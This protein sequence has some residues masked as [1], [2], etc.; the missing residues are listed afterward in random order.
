MTFAQFVMLT[1]FPG[2]ST[3][4]RGKRSL[5]AEPPRDRRRPG[6]A[7]LAD[8]AGTAAE[9]LHAASG[10]ERPRRSAAGRRASGT[11]STACRSIWER[12]RGRS[13]RSRRGLAFVLISKLYRQMYANTGIATDS[14][15]SQSLG[16]VG[17]MDGHAVPPAFPGRSDAGPAS[18]ARQAPPPDCFW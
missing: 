5:G 16:A 17:A 11:T 3:S 4:R 12:S 6:H 2:T 10:D 7:P 1:P 13:S 9:G 18:A 15:A 8:S 14:A